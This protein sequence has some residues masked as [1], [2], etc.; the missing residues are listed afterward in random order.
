[1]RF[2]TV[3]LPCGALLGVFCLF[4]LLMYWTKL[5]F[6]CYGAVGLVALIGIFVLGFWRCPHCGRQLGALEFGKKV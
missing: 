3:Q 5:A 6:F 2:R 1:M 4:L